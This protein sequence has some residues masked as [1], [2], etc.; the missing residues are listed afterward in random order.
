MKIKFKRF[1]CQEDHPLP[2]E[3]ILLERFVSK[4]SEIPDHFGMK[5]C[6]YGWVYLEDG[7]I[8]KEDED[9]LFDI[10]NEYS[11]EEIVPA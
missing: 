5:K 11:M 2:L 6:R 10:L 3:I 1:S 4:V 8:N 9:L 7:Q